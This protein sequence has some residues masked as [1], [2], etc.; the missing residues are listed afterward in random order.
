[1][2]PEIL[3]SQIDDYIPKKESRATRK[4]LSERKFRSFVKALLD[5]LSISINPDNDKSLRALRLWTFE[6]R[7]HYSRIPINIEFLDYLAKILKTKCLEQNELSDTLTVHYRLGDLLS[8]TNKT[9]VPSINLIKLVEDIYVG[10]SYNK[11]LIFSDSIEIAEKKLEELTK[12][13]NKIEYSNAPTLTVINNCLMSKYFI[14]TNSKVSFWIEILRQHSR[15]KSTIIGRNQ[16]N[17]L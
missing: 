9:Y 4:Y 10:D 7:G 13:T 3:I 2:P 12:F 11:I 15:K 17:N 14:G 8:L 16:P 1:L 5:K 6:I